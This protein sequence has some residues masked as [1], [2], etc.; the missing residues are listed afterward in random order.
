MLT[1]N[2]SIITQALICWIIDS[3][4]FNSR[5][6]PLLSAIW[7]ATTE[8]HKSNGAIELQKN[9]SSDSI[10]KPSWN[11]ANTPEGSVAGI[12]TPNSRMLI[13]SKKWEGTNSNKQV[14][15][16]AR[17]PDNEGVPPRYR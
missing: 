11:K 5:N 12:I 1:K 13:K 10:T 7:A 4:V 16:M 3:D 14:I 17:L 2:T 15:A 9:I 8:L 6:E